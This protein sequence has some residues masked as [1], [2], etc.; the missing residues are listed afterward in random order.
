MF[1]VYFWYLGILLL[2]YL[3]SVLGSDGSMIRVFVWLIAVSE[4]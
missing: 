2:L 3:L 1:F 4:A